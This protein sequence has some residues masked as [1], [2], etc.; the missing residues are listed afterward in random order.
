M[1][2]VGLVGSHRRNGNSYL[3]LNEA[4]KHCDVEWEIVQ[5]AEARIECCNACGLC[6]DTMKCVIDDM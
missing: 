3:I 2:I 5:L 4:L 1:K 6:K